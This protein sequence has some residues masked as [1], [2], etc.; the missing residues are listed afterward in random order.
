VDFDG[1]FIVI[2]CGAITDV[3]HTPVQAL[4]VLP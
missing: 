4:L 1:K 3:G 2:K